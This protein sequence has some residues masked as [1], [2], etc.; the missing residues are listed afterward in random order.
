MH[1]SLGGANNINLHPLPVTKRNMWAKEGCPL[2]QVIN[3][4]EE[5]LLGFKYKD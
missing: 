1:L 2:C 5:D 4:D 3:M